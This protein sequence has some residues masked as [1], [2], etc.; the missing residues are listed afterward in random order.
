MPK[1]QLSTEEKQGVMVCFA[2]LFRS[3]ELI[4]GIYFL[5]LIILLLTKTEK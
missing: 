1:L 4:C 3:R 2:Q 5:L